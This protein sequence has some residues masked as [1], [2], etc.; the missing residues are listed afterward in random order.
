MHN[1]TP[2]WQWLGINPIYHCKTF[3]IKNKSWNRRFR[4]FFKRCQTSPTRISSAEQ[5]ALSYLW[6]P[7]AAEQLIKNASKKQFSHAASQV[8]FKQTKSQTAQARQGTRQHKHLR[9]SQALCRTTGTQ[10]WAGLATRI[11]RASHLPT[12][13]S[14]LDLGESC[15]ELKWL[16]LGAKHKLLNR[17][18]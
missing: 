15:G 3:R 4:W 11:Q 12:N 9:T 1:T 16:A 17:E 18:K 5:K 14:F 6:V 2:K 7:P 8:L 13:P 10:L